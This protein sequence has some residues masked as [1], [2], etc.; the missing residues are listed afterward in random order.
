MK[1]LR[2]DSSPMGENSISRQLTNEFMQRWREI[3]PAGAVISRDLSATEIPVIDA[4]WIKAA[5]APKGS[6]SQEQEGFL[7]LSNELTAELLEAD[8]YVIGVATHNRGPSASFKLW[9]D[10]IVRFGETVLVTPS[11]TRGALEKKRATFIIAAGRNYHA[12]SPDASQEFV[13]PWLRGLFDYLGVKEMRFVIAD[14]TASLRHGNVDRAAF[15]AP[16]REAMLDLFAEEVTASRQ[17]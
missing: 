17:A 13:E 15:L 11:G 8:E 9:V 1:L 2:I 3:Y 12:G 16:H 5:L 10:Q 4:S 6:R 14:G 7:K